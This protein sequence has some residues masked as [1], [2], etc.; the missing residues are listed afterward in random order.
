LPSAYVVT[1][2]AST[3]GE[4]SV[5]PLQTVALPIGTHWC[6]LGAVSIVVAFTPETLCPF[7]DTSWITNERVLGET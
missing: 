3:P 1:E 4:P 5:E 7:T 2:N 6:E